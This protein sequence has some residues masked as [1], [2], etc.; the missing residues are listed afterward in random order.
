MLKRWLAATFLPVLLP[1][2]CAWVRAQEQRILAGG[3]P[4]PTDSLADARALGVSDPAAVRVLCVNRVPLPS[5]RLTRAVARLTGSLSTEPIG[6]A[7]GRGIY[8]RAGHEG[9]ALL[10]HELV[11]T[12]QYER[13]GGIR[14]FLRQYL[15]ECMVLGYAGAPLEREAIERS[16]NL[17]A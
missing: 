3:T 7:A 5:N 12:A 17:R 11:H 14:P 16:A 9:R 13:L 15:C 2:A 10:A 6:L 8:V 4:L 1:L